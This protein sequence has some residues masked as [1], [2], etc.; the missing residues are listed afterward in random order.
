MLISPRHTFRIYDEAF[1]RQAVKLVEES[2]HPMTAIARALGIHDNNL[3]KWVKIQHTPY[4]L[5]R[6]LHQDA[7][8]RVWYSDITHLHTRQ[9]VVYV[10]VVM[11][12]C[13][14]GLDYCLGR[15]ET[16]FSPCLAI[17]EK[18]DF[19]RYHGRIYAKCLHSYRYS[20][21]APDRSV[22]IRNM[23]NIE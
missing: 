11:D 6:R 3:R 5:Q 14:H 20:S 23:T 22:P 4:L 13:S 2:K 12:V 21:D 7:P 8:N 10:S 1:M 16:T 15:R 19:R 18:S 17:Q 9:G